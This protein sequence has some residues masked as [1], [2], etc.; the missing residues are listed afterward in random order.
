MSRRMLPMR[1]GFSSCI[2]AV[3]NLSRNSSSSSSPSRAT[4]SLS[5]HSR[6]SPAFMSCSS[7]SGP[8]LLVAD[9][10]LGPDRQLRG[11]QVHGLPR[12]LLV[13]SLELEQHPTRLD[14]A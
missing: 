6:I 1:L 8:E 11:R 14:H 7:S 5:S 4:I 2:V 13:D 12:G 10:E 9:H 3:L